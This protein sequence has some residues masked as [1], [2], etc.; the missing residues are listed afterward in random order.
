MWAVGCCQQDLVTQPHLSDFGPVAG[1]HL[2][3]DLSMNP[4][5]KTTDS[6]FL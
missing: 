4:V 5:P 3:L 1:T 6:M 2:A